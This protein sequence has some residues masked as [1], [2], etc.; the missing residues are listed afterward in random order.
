MKNPKITVVIPALNEEE[1]IGACI[2]SLL[3]QD[4]GAESIEILVVDGGSN[5]DTKNIIKSYQ[6]K[7][8]QVKLL[9]NK[10]RYTVFSFNIGINNASNRSQYITFLNCHALYEKN[11]LRKS[12][13]LIESDK[14]IDAVG[15]YSEA[16]SRT[17]S[18][19]ARSVSL[20]LRSRFSTGSKFRAGGLK[21]EFVDTASGCLYRKSLFD[22]IGLFNEKLICSQD[23]ELNKRL[24]LAG[25]KILYAPSLKTF[26]KSRSSIKKFINHTFRNGKWAILPFKYS[27]VVAVSARHM[28]PGILLILFLGVLLG[29]ALK[30][31][32]VLLPILLIATYLIAN[33]IFSAIIAIKQKSFPLF[34][35]AMIAFALFHSVYA[36]GSAYGLVLLLNKD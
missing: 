26:Y 23:I 3:K 25:G 18:L 12:I 34:F 7:Y 9:K 17:D 21:V 11:R 22:R 4:L 30:I 35:L 10:K 20:I 28:L 31:F 19:W 13:E 6:T 14:K 33:S 1:F 15:G 24:R 2:D 29:V 8:P 36:L 16:V 32:P 27:N 5:D